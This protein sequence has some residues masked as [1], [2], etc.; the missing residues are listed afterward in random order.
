MGEV[1]LRSGVLQVIPL[2]KIAGV[3][4]SDVGPDASCIGNPTID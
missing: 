3:R 1:L 4:Y 2:P